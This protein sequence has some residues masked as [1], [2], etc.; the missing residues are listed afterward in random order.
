MNIPTELLRTLVTVVDQVEA[1]VQDDSDDRRD[2]EGR[3]D[4]TKGDPGKETDTEQRHAARNQRRA[5][6]VFVGE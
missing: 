2:H 5:P 4:P 3:Q 1:V 6:E